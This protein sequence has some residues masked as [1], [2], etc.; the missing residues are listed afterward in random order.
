MAAAEKRSSDKNSPADE[1]LP[2]QDLADSVNPLYSL[3]TSKSDHS[4]LG[5]QF[6]PGTID[7]TATES[8]Q[9]L[10]SASP[11]GAVSSAYAPHTDAGGKGGVSSSGS[12]PL[13]TSLHIS[14]PPQSSSVTEEQQSA[15]AKAPAPPAV[16]VRLVRA[17]SSAK[18]AANI[19]QVDCPEKIV[20]KLRKMFHITPPT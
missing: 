11:D 20:S 9:G 10:I 6:A 5:R 8:V 13:M 16:P 19:P 1:Q 15:S 2:E 14:R 17:P 18:P 7:Q 12:L 4:S 3:A